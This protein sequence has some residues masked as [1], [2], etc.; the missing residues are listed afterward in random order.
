LGSAELRELRALVDTAVY[1]TATREV[2]L[3]GVEFEGALDLVD[4]MLAARQAS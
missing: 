1:S 3:R 2:A 4:A